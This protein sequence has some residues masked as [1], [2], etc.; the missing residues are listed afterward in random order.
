MEERLQKIMARYGIASRRKSEEFIQQGLVTVN[1]APATLGMKA[2]PLRDH[3]KVKNKLIA[4]PEPFVY[5]KFNKPIGCVTTMDDPEGRATIKDYL[6]KIKYRVYPVGRL[7]YNSEGLLLITNDGDFANKV[8]HPSNEIKRMYYV[9]INGFLD[10][11][12][13]RKLRKGVKLDDGM[14]AAS[15]VRTIKGFENNSWVEITIAEGRN[16]QIRRMFQHLGFS[17]RKLQR[18]RIGAIH[19]G[20]LPLGHYDYLTEREIKSIKGDRVK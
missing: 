17:I 10:E 2:D 15:S 14:A 16:Q 3:I 18:V 8:L 5:L 6:T 20:A 4:K 7:D 1:G 12:A 9:K 13:T 19:L 11:E